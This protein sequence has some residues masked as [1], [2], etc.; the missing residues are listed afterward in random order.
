MLCCL[1]GTV[2]LGDWFGCCCFGWVCLL[3]VLGAV[4]CCALFRIC[5][6]IVCDFSCRGGLGRGFCVWD[7]LLVGYC[8][9]FVVLL[10]LSCLLGLVLRLLVGF[11]ALLIVVVLGLRYGDLLWQYLVC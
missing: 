5:V 6:F 4:V 10:F 1:I 11:V 8:G 9:R 7:L 2:L 3:W